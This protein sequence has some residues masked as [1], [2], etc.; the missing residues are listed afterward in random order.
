MADHTVTKN[1]SRN[2]RYLREDDEDVVQ[3]P[4]ES[5]DDE[6]STDSGCSSGGSTG[7]AETIS[8]RG[9]AD[10]I[11]SYHHL[12]NHN[13]HHNNNKNNQLHQNRHHVH[14]R[15]RSTGD[16][17]S[18]ATTQVVTLLPRKSI[19]IKDRALRSCSPDEGHCRSYRVSIK[20]PSRSE[21]PEDLDTA[22]RPSIIAAK[23]LRKAFQ[24]L[25]IGAKQVQE[26]QETNK[27]NNAKTQAPQ[28]KRIL[29][30]PVSYTYAK[31]LSGL[32]T[33]RIPRL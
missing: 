12:N 19:I 33:Q 30:N 9:S 20:T 31:G 2:L 13:N 15:S 4:Q 23:S 27:T 6:C 10:P 29:R 11:D 7:S 1:N 18:P 26:P 25:K 24:H 8:H 16:A 32:P 21:S 3:D 14:F 5:I 28:P 22:K 17:H